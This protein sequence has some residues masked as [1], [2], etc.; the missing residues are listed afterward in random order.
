MARIAEALG[1]TQ[2]TISEDLRGLEAT[3]KPSR[4]KGGRPKGDGAEPGRRSGPPIFVGFC[5]AKAFVDSNRQFVGAGDPPAGPDR[6]AIE[7]NLFGDLLAF[8]IA[9][10][11][12]A[13][14]PIRPRRDEVGH[15]YLT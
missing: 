4:P 2:R 14:Y 13:G 15:Y 7:P 11:L 8:A 5:A 1:V 6:P 12:R 3:S 10:R 9:A